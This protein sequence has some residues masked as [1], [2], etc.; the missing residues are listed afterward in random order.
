MTNYRW[1]LLPLLLSFFLLVAVDAHEKCATNEP[2]LEQSS[3][4]LARMKKWA[5][6]NERKLIAQSCDE[7]CNQCI[8]IDIYF[9]INVLKDATSPTGY[10]VPHPFRAVDNLLE[11]GGASVTL[12]DFSDIEQINEFITFQV[13]VLNA[14]FKDTPFRFV[15]KNPQGPTINANNDHTLYALSHFDE[16]S[17]ILRVG[18][19]KVLNVYLSYGI[20]TVDDPKGPHC[21]TLGLSFFPSY[22]L[23]MNGDGVHMRI[24][25]LTGGG[26]PD[27]D[28]GLTLVHEVGHWLGLYHTFSNS[29]G[30]DGDPCSPANANDYVID[31]PVQAAPSQNMYNC[32]LQLYEEEAV[33]DSCPNI[34]GSD[35]VFNFMNYVTNEQCQPEGKGEFTCG[36]IERMVSKWDWWYFGLI[37]YF[38]RWKLSHLFIAVG[39]S[40]HNGSYIVSVMRY[41]IYLRR[42]RWNSL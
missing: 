5:K 28:S 23:G 30:E 27:N 39:T 14:R 36:Q 22:N 17:R 26:F 42:S 6:T 2:S 9:H 11:K 3:R 29:L 1:S 33:P 7:L 34:L 25:T 35:P 37:D 20:C 8:P 15:H 32:S 16:Y 21:A 19:N 31:T 4:D 24:D 18:D 12:E 40:T 38:K 41:A 10:V 13:K